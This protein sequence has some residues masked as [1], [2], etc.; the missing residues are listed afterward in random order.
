MI[1]WGSVPV[2]ISVK[3]HLLAK[4]LDILWS[5]RALHGPFDG[6]H[7]LDILQSGW[8][9]LNEKSGPSSRNQEV[10]DLSISSFHENLFYH[11]F[12]FGLT[13]Q[14]FGELSW[15]GFLWGV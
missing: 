14:L 1:V 5:S 7:G 10:M 13:G 3:V 12:W 8:A 9:F 15:Q 2:F 11:Q 4:E 6:K